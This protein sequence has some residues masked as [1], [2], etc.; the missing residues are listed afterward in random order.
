MPRDQ[1]T[2]GATEARKRLMNAAKVGDLKEIA[3]VLE[4]RKHAVTLRN[5]HHNAALRTAV[6]AGQVQAAQVLV[7]NGADLNQLNHGGSSFLEAASHNGHRDM[8]LW[9]VKQGLKA[10][11]FEW[12]A[13][14]GSRPSSRHY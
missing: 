1:I 3:S 2:L 6:S 5:A 11:I 13:V 9:L 8:V 12:S 4:I 14:G 7:E 10:K